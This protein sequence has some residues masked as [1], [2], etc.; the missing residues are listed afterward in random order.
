VDDGNAGCGHLT[1]RP[2]YPEP[3]WG[4]RLLPYREV[5]DGVAVVRLPIWPGRHSI[6]ERLP[7][8]ASFVVALS[9][10]APFLGPP[11]SIVAVSPSFRPSSRRC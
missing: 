11:D 2:H 1:A 6:G 7:Q 10:A 3:K 5:R 9:A 4:T 8:E